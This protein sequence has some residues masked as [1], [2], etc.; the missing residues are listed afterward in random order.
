MPA[1]GMD[2]ALSNVSAAGAGLVALAWCFTGIAFL[3][4]AATGQRGNVLAV[5]G[6]IGVA[7][8]MANA[9]SGLVDG[10]QWLRWPSPFHYFIGVDPLHTGWHPGA[11]LVL[12]GVAA[13][14]TAA[15]V[16]LFDRR[17]VGV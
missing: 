10:W 2:I 1:I 6:I 7:T 13:V 11:L 3:V 8:Y 9:I 14:T 12:V 16:A 15:G 5:T 4:G 17:D